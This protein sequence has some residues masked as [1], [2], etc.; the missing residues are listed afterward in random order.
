MK[1]VSLLVFIFALAIAGPC[2]A[3][4]DA[5][6]PPSSSAAPACIAASGQDCPGA[7]Q[8]DAALAAR[9]LSA[10]FGDG[11]A[12]FAERQAQRYAAEHDE[13]SA[14]FWRR[15]A[16]LAALQ[17]QEIGQS[18]SAGAIATPIGTAR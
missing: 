3:M 16:R 2:W 18:G 5:A 12:A 7:A 17:P 6:Q 8:D 10:H 14:A 4:I 1:A 13:A 11:A 15:V 9:L